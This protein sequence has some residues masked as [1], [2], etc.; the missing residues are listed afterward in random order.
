M[1]KR[2]LRDRRGY[3]LV[4]VLCILLLFTALGVNAL[5]AANATMGAAA[6][7]QADAQ[8]YTLAVSAVPQAQSWVEG[9][10]F[11]PLIQA[12]LLDPVAAAYTEQSLAAFPNRKPPVSARAAAPV[13]LPGGRDA[14]LTL[15]FE[16]EKAHIVSGRAAGTL[17]VR[18]R[19]AYGGVSCAFVASYAMR[20]EGDQAQFQQL[21]VKAD[22]IREGA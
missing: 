15:E 9:G 19:A 17:L 6:A 20:Y 4:T 22:R 21:S 13:S 18:V 7:Q 11:T 5:V 14:E 16:L 2:L 1:A 12:Q 10:A 3:A 8:A